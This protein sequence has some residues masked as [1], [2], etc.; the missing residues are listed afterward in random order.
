M[1]ARTWNLVC[2]LLGSN[3]SPLLGL[4]HAI[5]YNVDAVRYYCNQCP[6]DDNRYCVHAFSFCVVAVVSCLLFVC[7]TERAYGIMVASVRAY[8]VVRAS[9]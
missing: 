3:P 8:P 7:I 2:A 6:A 9:Q 4:Y 5:G 1:P